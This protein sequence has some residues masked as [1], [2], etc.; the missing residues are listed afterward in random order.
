MYAVLYQIRAQVE[1]MTVLFWD[2]YVNEKAAV[3]L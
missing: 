2:I 1:T 3:I